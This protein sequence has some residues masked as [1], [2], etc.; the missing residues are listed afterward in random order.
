MS[1]SVPTQDHENAL[2]A[3][4]DT[5]KLV[6]GID[7]GTTYSGIA[8]GLT[9]TPSVQEYAAPGHGVGVD[10]KTR[11]TLIMKAS[12]HTTIGFGEI[13]YEKMV[14]AMEEADSS[15]DFESAEEFDWLLFERF[16]MKLK[17][18]NSGYM[19]LEARS[20]SGEKESLMKLISE[21]LRL[22]KECAM[23]EIQKAWADGLHLDQEKDIKW[24]ITVP[25]IWTDFAKTFM[26]KAAEE[27]GIVA[28]SADPRLVLAYE[29]EC[30][31]LAVHDKTKNLSL[32]S[33]GVKYMILDCGGGTVDI[34]G[35]CVDSVAPL[36]LKE[37]FTADG[38]DWGGSYVNA[39]FYDGF[40]KELIGETA[41]NLIE[42]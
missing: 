26:R 42:T 36:V 10:P 39:E 2:G 19:S 13:A 16:K 29:P 20:S 21:S 1:S 41:F 32:L 12:D 7:F 28:S 5:Y 4:D 34:T 11:T 33:P 37:I 22:L 9:A 27:A 30:A 18:Q 17:G 31:A 23:D 25:A 6:I 38:G 35:H 40:L 24:V 14:E 15:T 8:W 3:V